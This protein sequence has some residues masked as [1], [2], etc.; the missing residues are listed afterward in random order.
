MNQLPQPQEIH[1]LI[2]D[3]ERLRVHRQDLL[4]HRQHLLQERQ[5]LLEHRQHL[6][7]KKLEDEQ[8]LIQRLA[9]TPASTGRFSC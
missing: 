9:G 8:A 4:R 6:L 2:E 3:C 7:Q 5:R 1:A